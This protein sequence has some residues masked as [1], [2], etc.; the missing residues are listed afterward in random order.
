MNDQFDEQA[1]DVSRLDGEL[2]TDRRLVA[3]ILRQADAN[4]RAAI[5]QSREAPADDPPLRRCEKCGAVDLWSC[6]RAAN[7]TPCWR[8][9]VGD[10]HTPPCTRTDEHVDRGCRAAS[11]WGKQR[12]RLYHGGFHPGR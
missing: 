10:M 6:W 2:V 8:R 3:A 5:E 7:E 9:G 12:G 11:V 4:A 1:D